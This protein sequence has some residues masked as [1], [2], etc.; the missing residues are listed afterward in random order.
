MQQHAEFVTITPEIAAEWLHQNSHNRSLK[1]SVIERY[2][3]AMRRGEWNVNGDAI[4]FAQDGALLDGQHRLA[5]IYRS[6]TTLVQ[7]VVRGLESDAQETMDVGV[8]RSLKDMLKLRGESRP[9]ELG[10]ALAWLHRY[11]LRQ[12]IDRSLVPTPQE[13]FRLLEDNPGIRESL[14]VGE[15][16]GKSLR[17]SRGLVIALHYVFTEIDQEDA[18]TFF[19]R[20]GSGAE[21]QETDPIHVLRRVVTADSL[22]PQ[23]MVTYRLAALTIKAWNAYRDGRPI[24]LLRWKSGGAHPEAFPYPL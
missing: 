17:F 3:G 9:G 23:R 16:V 18:D 24:V 13:A 19:E 21:L 20:L 5:A 12:M 8:R 7:L 4:R 15:R 1:P 22:A 2:A 11:R 6:G 10:S 14:V